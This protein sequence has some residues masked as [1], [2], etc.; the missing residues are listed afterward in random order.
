M[1]TAILALCVFVVAFSAV[2][3]GLSF[4]DRP[5]AA[6][7]AKTAAVQT[8]PA[9]PAETVAD[10]PTPAADDELD[11][12][13]PN[14]PFA[15][16]VAEATADG[17]RSFCA[18][19][20]HNPRNH[21]VQRFG[22]RSGWSHMPA[23][24]R[25][26]NNSGCERAVSERGRGMSED[27]FGQVIYELVR[28]GGPMP[29]ERDHPRW[30]P[31]PGTHLLTT[32]MTRVPEMSPAEQKALAAKDQAEIDRATAMIAAIDFP[33]GRTAQIPDG[34]ANDL[35]RVK[36]VPIRHWWNLWG[37]KKVKM[38]CVAAGPSGEPQGPDAV[39]RYDGDHFAASGDPRIWVAYCGGQEVA[40][41]SIS[42]TDY[43]RQILPLLPA[44]ELYQLR[45]TVLQ[46][47]IDRPTERPAEY[48]APPSMSTAL[49]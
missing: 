8:R 1:K 11:A 45:H 48:V 47:L 13:D 27:R 15:Y 28:L 18:E 5:G 39:L 38:I 12:E 22:D 43:Y 36:L 3:A 4:V 17:Q 10:A 29:H 40:G 30:R 41:R 42:L 37:H 20:I 6:K 34:S 19:S 32:H 9:A 7:P 33:L 2:L 14:H 25:D 24:Q 46:E 44:T 35:V 23:T 21:F 49:D 16:R 26:W 31:P